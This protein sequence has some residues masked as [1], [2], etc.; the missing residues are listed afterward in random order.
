MLSQSSQEVPGASPLSSS[1]S[2][3]L[4][5]PNSSQPSSQ[6]ESGVVV[7]ESSVSGVTMTT[8]AMDTSVARGNNQTLIEDITPVNKKSLAKALRP[9]VTIKNFFKPHEKAETETATGKEELSENNSFDRK[10][11]LKDSAKGEKATKDVVVLGEGCTVV[12]KEMSYEEFLNAG[13]D[14]SN[15]KQETQGS[16]FV[17]GA[18]GSGSSIKAMRGRADKTLSSKKRVLES[19]SC[20]TQPKKKAKQITLFS[21]FE[22]MAAKKSEDAAKAVTCPV[23]QTVFD[24]G[25]SNSELNK[26]I[27]NCI[28]E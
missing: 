27:D 28:I 24:K 10:E 16:D 26:H 9:P 7:S 25:I 19:E 14:T 22:K 21:T 5:S 13:C 4:F 1:P 15:V 11:D 12:K 23:C 8:V 17:P 20:S 3:P 18:S 6:T 2:Q